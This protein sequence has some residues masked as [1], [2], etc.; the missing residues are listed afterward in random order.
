MVGYLGD[1]VFEDGGEV[2]GGAGANAVR[3]AVLLDIA[4][5]AA[6]GKL[7]SSLRGPGHRL[8]PLAALPPGHLP[9]FSGELESL[10][11]WVAALMDVKRGHRF[12]MGG[13]P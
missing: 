1:K 5:D 2:G 7:E 4:P 10:E 13:A 11:I 6:D 12:Y 9:S 3:V 8:L